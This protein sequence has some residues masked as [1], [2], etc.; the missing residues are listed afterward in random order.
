MEIM[1]S[2]KVLTS[3]DMFILGTL[4]YDPLNRATIKITDSLPAS[5]F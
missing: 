5:K 3:C 1:I 2:V 4:F